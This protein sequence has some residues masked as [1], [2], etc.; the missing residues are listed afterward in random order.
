M[1]FDSFSE[2]MASPAETSD[3]IAF[4][5]GYVSTWLVAVAIV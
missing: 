3:K 5:A 2:A 1:S 4:A